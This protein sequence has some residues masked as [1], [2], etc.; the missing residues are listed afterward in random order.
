MNTDHVLFVLYDFPPDG[1]RGTKRS[2]KFIRYLPQYRWSAI[3]LTVQSPHFDFYD[4]SLFA[5][6]PEN[7]PVY[8]ARTLESLI[9]QSQYA[10]NEARDPV[11]EAK[12]APA[13]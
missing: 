6:L 11:V 4:G 12:K 5:E 9:H 7:L 13:P 2:L 8:R 10:Q 3:V 1:A